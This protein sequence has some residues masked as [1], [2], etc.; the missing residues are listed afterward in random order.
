MDG[1][2]GEPKN[3]NSEMEDLDLMTQNQQHTTKCKI[4]FLLKRKQVYNHGCH[5]PSS[6][7]HLIIEM[8]IDSWHT[9]LN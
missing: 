2:A 8:K 5:L 9:T 1:L 7:T 4:I 3:E 6:L